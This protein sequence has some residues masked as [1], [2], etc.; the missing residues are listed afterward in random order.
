VKGV[1]SEVF[2]HCPAQLGGEVVD[3]CLGSR[4]LYGVTS[5]LLFE[6]PNFVF[7]GLLAPREPRLHA[8]RSTLKK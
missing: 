2:L 6:T 7:L 3:L 4:E 8:Y 5:N 1:S